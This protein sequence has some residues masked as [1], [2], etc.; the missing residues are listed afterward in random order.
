[1]DLA[2]VMLF[3]QIAIKICQTGILALILIIYAKVLI[4]TLM[5]WVTPHD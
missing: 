4:N 1:M 2:E 3:A 5:S